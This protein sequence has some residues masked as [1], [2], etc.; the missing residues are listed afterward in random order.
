VAGEPM[1]AGGW[2][3]RTESLAGD[4]GSEQGSAEPKRLEGRAAAGE[5]PVGDRRS[6]PWCGCVSTAGHEDPRGKPGRPRSKATYA[7]RPIAHE[8][9][10]GKVKSTPAR[11]V[12]ESLKPSAYS[13][14]EV[15]L[16]G[17]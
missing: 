14:R 6:P 15:P 3:A 11:G 2:T 9:R 4:S 5:S 13:Q 1:C 12:K 10:E 7:Q 16:R 17:G 8:Y